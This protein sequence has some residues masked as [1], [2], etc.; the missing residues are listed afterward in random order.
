M[1][2]SP[3]TNIDVSY[4]WFQP[5]V[6]TRRFAALANNA[7]SLRSCE[8]WK[9]LTFMSYHLIFNFE[10]GNMTKSSLLFRFTFRK[11]DVIRLC[12]QDTEFAL[13]CDGR[14]SQESSAP[15][16]RNSLDQSAYPV[17]QAGTAVGDV[18]VFNNVNRGSRIEEVK[19]N[20]WYILVALSSF[21]NATKVNMLIQR[22]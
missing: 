21:W 10:T 14:S 16:Y 5:V 15:H 3:K 6:S 4:F 1:F 11:I 2:S 13:T 12:L 7:Y 18:G 22:N 17:L 19:N 9:L 8:F 20:F